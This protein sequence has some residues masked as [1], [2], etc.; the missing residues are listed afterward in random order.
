VYALGV[1]YAHGRGVP[2]DDAEAL[3]WYR[4][5]AA[6]GLAREWNEAHRREP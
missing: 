1:L 5:A 3:R 6:Q 4:L 2:Q